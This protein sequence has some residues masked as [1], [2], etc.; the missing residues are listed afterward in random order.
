MEQHCKWIVH[1]TVGLRGK[2]C[3]RM[4][5]KLHLPVL[6]QWGTLYEPLVSEPVRHLEGYVVT[7]RSIREQLDAS[8][9]IPRRQPKLPCD[10]NG[11]R[12]RPSNIPDLAWP[13]RLCASAVL[14]SCVPVL[15]GSG[16][17]WAVWWGSAHKPQRHPRTAPDPPKLARAG[18]KP[19]RAGGAWLALGG[20]CA[21]TLATGSGRPGSLA[22]DCCVSCWRLQCRAAGVH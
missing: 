20:C 4:R 10:S 13:L 6:G 9:S 8:P 14:R 2:G 22:P 3:T 18:P 16:T 12:L 11:P 15:A 7:R 5:P 1:G 17:P 21:P 19:A